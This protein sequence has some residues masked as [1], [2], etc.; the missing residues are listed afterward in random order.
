MLKGVTS[1]RLT[2]GDVP[3]DDPEWVFE[4]KYDGFR[5][6]AYVDGDDVRGQSLLERKACLLALVPD[7]DPRLLYLD[8]IEERRV[9]LFEKIC[10]MDLEG[11]NAKRKKGSIERVR[12]G[13][14]SKTATTLRPKGVVSSSSSS[15]AGHQRGH[16]RVGRTVLPA[17]R[18]R[19]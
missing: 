14:K 2:L 13:S 19:E 15:G 5:A 10:E 12:A 18:L 3:F 4:L 7:G 1:L 17:A 6:L 8:H 16:R 11:I 9:A